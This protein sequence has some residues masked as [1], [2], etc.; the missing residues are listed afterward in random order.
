MDT[1][2]MSLPLFFSPAPL[3]FIFLPAVCV[4]D[5]LAFLFHLTTFATLYLES[6]SLGLDFNCIITSISHLLGLSLSTWSMNSH[7]L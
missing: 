3:L 2:Y 1:V 5:T 7:I 4:S 6:F